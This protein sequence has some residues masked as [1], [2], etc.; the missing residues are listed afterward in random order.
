M[1]IILTP[2]LLLISLIL[3]GQESTTIKVIVPNKTDEVFIVGNQ[4]NLGNWNPSKVKM[5]R[6]SDFERELTIPLTFPAEFK[7]TKGGWKNEGIIKSL[8]DNPNLIMVDK[9]SKNIFF[10]KNWS[11]E[12]R[13]DELCQQYDI[14]K[15]NSEIL[16]EERILKIALPNNYDRNKKY[17]VVFITDAETGNFEVALTYINQLIKNN[18]I[19]EIILV[20]INQ[21]N[22]GA[23][24][25]VFW[26]E[27]GEKFK[28]HLFDEIIPYINSNYSTSGFN[29]IIGHSDG[30][31]Y[32]HL[33]MLEK[34][35]PFR[36]FVNISTNLN[37][38]V[39]TDIE[40]FFKTPNE[41]TVYYFISNGKYD[42]EDR[43]MAGNKI[44]SLFKASQNENIKFVKKDYNADHQNLVSKSMFDGISLIFK[45]YRNLDNY[46]SFKDYSQ[47]YQSEINRLYGFIPKLEE[48]DIDFY[49]GKIL[50]EKNIDDY[51]YL[52]S[53]TEE[54]NILFGNSLDRA[55]HYFYMEQYP[56]AINFWNKTINQFE[57]IEP[58]VFYYNFTK[59]ID[60]YLIEKNPLG[61]IEFLEKSKKKMPEYSL[62]F[63]YFIAKTSIENNVE[64]QKGKKALKNCKSN[65]KENR[66]FSE[67]ELDELEQK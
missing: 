50:D 5:N 25:D 8:S 10:I 15:I 40:K 11:D 6:T 57:N 32:N 30:A 24:L 29:T 35:N 20:G 22:R 2:F 45:D 55:N 47:N 41:K 16:K 43:I 60:A 52:I 39:S 26:S 38:D 49:F 64:V 17:P 61:A 12:I 67:K 19:P 7:F 44:D 51:E 1:K 63:D 48:N 58:R 13:S 21:N 65:Y 56:Q 42:S 37:N 14:K 9:N 18:A 54:N 3:F 53:F 34:N 33:L 23:E 31:E 66:Y 62:E 4:E 36:G 28:N 59:A 27:N 46:G